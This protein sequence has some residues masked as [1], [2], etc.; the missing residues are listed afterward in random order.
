MHGLSYST[1]APQARSTRRGPTTLVPAGGRAALLAGALAL[2]ACGGGNDGGPT[3]PSGPKPGGTISGRYTLELTPAAACK[4]RS[5][6]FNVEVTQS[7]SAPHPGSQLL[8][9]AADPAMLELE[10]KYTDD[11]LEGGVGTTGDGQPAN[12]GPSVWV[13]AIA[14]GKTTQ[15]SD[16]RGEVTAGTLRGYLEIDGVMDA[17]SSTGHTFTLRAK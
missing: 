11:T 9:V 5:L 1:A 2:A 6:T 13:N 3:G 7:G 8:L 16:G 10:L 4:G 12:E 17:C 14:S 15:T